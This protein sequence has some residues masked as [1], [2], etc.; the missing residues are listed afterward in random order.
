MSEQSRADGGGQRWPQVVAT[1][2]RW[3]NFKPPQ[4]RTAVWLG[5]AGIAGLVLLAVR[6]ATGTGG[7][8]PP[9]PTTVSGTA[10]AG[11]PVNGVA[12]AAA[13]MDQQL[14][15][16]LQQVA[17]AGRVTVE[18]DMIAGPSAVFAS[19]TQ[20]NRTT[21]QQS[22][23]GG[24]SEQSVQQTSSTQ[25]VL[26]GSSPVVA[27][28][29]AASVAGVLVVATGATNP[30]VKAA[31]AEAA[32]AATGVPLYRVTVLAGGGGT[33]NGAAAQAR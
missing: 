26:A 6:P 7:T 22:P 9:A 13:A 11:G 29:R 28:T 17:G 3:F 23:A 16:V 1:W 19:N 20:T 8:T 12:G 21:S 4:W 27:T 15:Q 31:L 2:P 5:V 24:G 30:M 25:V 10:A 18:V 14:A 33:A 32:Q